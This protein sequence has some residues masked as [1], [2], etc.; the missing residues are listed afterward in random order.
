M[1]HSQFFSYP[2]E[3]AY[4][5]GVRWPDDLIIIAR[6]SIELVGFNVILNFF[7]F[8]DFIKI[9]YFTCDSIFL[10]KYLFFNKINGRFMISVFIDATILG[11]VRVHIAMC[12]IFFFGL[13]GSCG[14]MSYE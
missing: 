10:I 6:V 2:T 9:S 5:D 7:F 3:N 4:V 8:L 13:N 14:H 12:T 1:K 11:L